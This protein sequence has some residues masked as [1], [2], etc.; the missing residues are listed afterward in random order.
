MRSPSYLWRDRKPSLAVITALLALTSVRAGSKDA[1]DR[2]QPEAFW[3]VGRAVPIAVAAGRAGVG[4]PTPHPGSRTLVIVST[5]TR[6][7]GPFRVEMNARKSNQPI[8]PALADDGLER[9]PQLIPRSLP[10]IPPQRADAPPRERAFHVMVRDG[11][12]ASASNYLAIKGEL[13]AVG[14]RVQVYVDGADVSRV[15]AAVLHDLVATFDDQVFPIA[16]RTIGQAHDADEDG[17]FTVL[18]SSWLTRLAGGRHAVDGF[19]RGADFNRALPAPFSNH[20]D[21]MY[22]STTLEPGPH[23]RTVVA[24]EYTHAVTFTAKAFDPLR[25]HPAQEEEDW[26]DEALAH[27]TEDLHGFSR[28]NLDYRISAFLSQPERYRLVVEDYYAADLFRS[29]GNRGGTYLFLRWCADRFGPNLLPVLIQ[30]RQRGIENLEAATGQTFAAL[31]RQWS[32]ALFR[33]GFDLK[34]RHEND[35]HSLDVRRPINDWELAGPRIHAVKPGGAAETWTAVGTSSHYLVVESSPSGAVEVRVSGPP[36]ADLQVTVMPLP[37]EMAQI[38][39]SARIVEGPGGDLLLDASLRE[40]QGVAVELSALA[41]EPLVPSIDPHTADFRR[42]GLD[43]KGIESALGTSLLP[44]R[45][46]L[47]SNRI[48]LNRLRIGQL[49]LIVKAVGTDSHGQRVSAWAE[50]A[51]P[52]ED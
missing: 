42:A 22:L 36:E 39:L 33:S 38:E 51:V 19:V 40:R 50:I 9:A 7:P 43:R 11:D 16:A 47:S 27:L 5:L 18:I 35:F 48:P 10:P 31:Y 8:V 30:S 23:L 41:W 25:V 46:S 3:Q 17:R 45:G 26:L 12:V 29:H 14:R 2:G 37:P 52:R 6:A 13:R 28:S 20:C 4:V 32:I 34:N 1:A 21:M 49:P 15:G 44:P 24:H